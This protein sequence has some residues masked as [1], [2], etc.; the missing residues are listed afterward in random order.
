MRPGHRDDAVNMLWAAVTHI[1]LIVFAATWAAEYPVNW[2]YGEDAEIEGV[3]EMPYKGGDYPLASQPED[4][5]GV[6]GALC[7][8]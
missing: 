6:H 8:G 2:W 4:P 7:S 5:H 1:P 3:E